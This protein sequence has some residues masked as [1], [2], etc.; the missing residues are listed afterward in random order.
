MA[1]L[2]E[3]DDQDKLA[4]IEREIGKREFV[5]PR[6][7]AEKRMSSATAERELETMRAIANDYRRKAR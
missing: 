7:V 6:L 4:C 1:Q 5:Y 2:F 3:P